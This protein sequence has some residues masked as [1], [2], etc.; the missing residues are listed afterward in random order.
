MISAIRCGEKTCRYLYRFSP[1]WVVKYRHIG[2]Q[3]KIQYRASLINLQLIV[4]WALIWMNCQTSSASREIY[5]ISVV[6]TDSTYCVII[7][8]KHSAISK[9]QQASHLVSLG[10]TKS[11]ESL[12]FALSLSCNSAFE[13]MW[14]HF[15][16]SAR[17]DWRASLIPCHSS[18]LMGTSLSSGLSSSLSSPPDRQ[19]LCS[20]TPS[21]NFMSVD[22]KKT[23]LQI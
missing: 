13:E 20:I 11:T 23:Y 16:G 15:W 1:K 12:C 7:I 5:R 8:M 3:Q 18:A 17:V 6:I 19:L 2:Y 14:I 22:R 9:P 10:C 21:C 4:I